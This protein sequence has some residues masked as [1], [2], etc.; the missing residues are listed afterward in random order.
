[1]SWMN[2]ARTVTLAFVLVFLPSRVARA[3]ELQAL[4]EYTRPDPFGGVVNPD[5]TPDATRGAHGYFA[6]AAILEAARGGYASFHLVV[7]MPQ[8]GPY[9]LSLSMDQ[10][11]VALQPDLYREW[12]HFVDS[13]K[14]YYPDA[15]VPLKLPYRSQIPEDRK[16]T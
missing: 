12:F 14:H 7:K 16:S 3:A 6:R 13:D 15:L 1:M 9:V 4:S 5:A 10:G 8:R 11:A 2:L